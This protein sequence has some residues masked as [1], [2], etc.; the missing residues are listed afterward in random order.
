ME[1]GPRAVSE[2]KRTA[3]KAII[4]QKPKAVAVSKKYK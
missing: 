3:E 4:R 2:L 1:P